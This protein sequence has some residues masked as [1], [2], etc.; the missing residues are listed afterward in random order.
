MTPTSH[1]QTSMAYPGLSHSVATS[2]ASPFGMGLT[3]TPSIFPG[4]V[5]GPSP[6]GFSGFGGS[7]G[8]GAGSP[9]LSSFMGAGV[10]VATVAPLHS[11]A[12]ATGVPSS[13]PVLPGF[14][15]AFSSNFQPGLSSGLQPT[16]GAAFPG[17]L[18]FPGMP[19]FSPSPSQLHNPAMQSALRL[20]RA[21][22]P[23][24]LE[25]RNGFRPPPS[26]ADK[27]RADRI[28]H[29]RYK[30]KMSITHHT[31]AAAHRHSQTLKTLTRPP[32]R[33]PPELAT[34]KGARSTQSQTPPP[35]TL[36]SAWPC[37]DTTPDRR[38]TRTTQT[39]D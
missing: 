22:P 15:S 28:A 18:S 30:F 10:S 34:R 38:T 14:A 16:G 21:R 9:V 33:W 39:N 4:L 1:P 31:P 23:A 20:R 32:P 27:S 5:P 17:L 37:P 35:W 25:P 6:G 12:V 11:A 7:G 8:P 36:E 2:G 29:L 26:S 13:S 3:T 19:G 24:P